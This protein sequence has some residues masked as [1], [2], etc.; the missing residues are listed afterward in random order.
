MNAEIIAVGTEL[1]LGEIV[2]TNAQFLSDRLSQLGINVYYQV[3]VGDNKK[4]LSQTLQASLERSDMVIL[5]GGL[6]PTKDDLTKETIA[7]TLALPLELH[8]ESLKRIKDFYTSI[9]REMAKN[10]IK[11]AYLPKGA[12]VLKND[13]GTAPGCIIE[14]NNKVVV[15]L[16]GPPREMQPMFNN[17]V[18]PFLRRK[19]SDAIYSKVLRI[20]GVGE[21]SLEEKLEDLF[22]EQSNPTIAPYA[23]QGEVRLRITSKCKSEEEANKLIAPV[24]EEIRKRL[25]VTVY[26]E[27]EE[28]L[29]KVVAKLLMEKNLTIATAE[30][31]TGG[32]LA[33]KITRVPGI[34]KSF[35]KGVITYSNESKMELLGVKKET[36]QEFGAVS[37]QTAV[38]MAQGIRERSNVDIGVSITGIA[39]PGGGTKEKP[40]GL[41]YVGV[42][43]E[44]RTWFKELRLS[45]S[46]ENIRY[47]TTMHALDM[48]RRYMVEG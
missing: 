41:V 28:T 32:L 1:L 21:S 7:E 19:T 30:S 35:T 47:R 44:E 25:G 40:V 9:H 17:S 27:G 6:G 45:R 26:G 23:K 36:L 34:S 33:E 46:R 8:E 31:C 43:T 42:S 10:N 22:E 2:N 4:R 16:P 24:E 15:M 13:N 38:Q 39:G 5:T 18:Y 48:V 12:T 29:E 3:V 20:F 37:A 14:K 11:Q